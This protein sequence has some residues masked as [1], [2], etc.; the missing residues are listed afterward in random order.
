MDFDVI[1]LGAGIVGVSSALHLQDRGRRVAL[2]DRRGPGEETSFGNAGLIERSSVVPYGFPRDLGTLLRYMRNRSTDLYWDYKALPSFATWLARFWW[3]SSPERLEAAARDM[4][5]L[6][7]ASVAEYDVLIARA[8]L[9]RLAHD[10]GWLEAFR[11]RTEFERQAAAAEVTASQYG[12]RVA[13]L[14]AAR[15]LAREPGLGAGF[16]GALHWQDPKSISN[17]GALTKGYARLFKDDGGTL[18]IGEA[19]TVRLEADA[20]TVQTTQGRISAKEVVVALGPWSDKVFA[21][22]GY[23]IPL[24]AKRGYH[25]H[26]E[27]TKAMLSVPLVDTESGYVVAPMEGRLRLTTGVEIA[28]RDAAPTGI[29]LARAEGIARP[30]FGLG[31]RLDEA[32][33][34]GLRPCTPDMR[35]VIGRAP[36]HRGLWFA[37]GHNHHGLTLGPVTGRL[38][39]EMMTGAEPFA[40]PFPF[41][42]ERFR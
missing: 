22:L 15:L 19:T 36:R 10:G 37:F 30:V 14:D 5:P 32:P 17:P 18:L 1:V 26:Y 3:E 27:A 29:Q 31:R 7:R 41:R 20:W 34:L 24:R 42:P 8:G 35:P 38:L 28:R 6:I 4:L 39:A 25:M 13:P 23:R 16:C 40:D 9:E 21:P 33:W 2:V 12:L 11:T